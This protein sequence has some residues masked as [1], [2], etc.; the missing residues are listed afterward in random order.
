MYASSMPGVAESC[1]ARSE[2]ARTELV[3]MTQKPGASMIARA[4]N[5]GDA[6]TIWLNDA[7]SAARTTTPEVSA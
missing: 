6:W 3:E 7:A 1:R 4:L 2:A 5:D